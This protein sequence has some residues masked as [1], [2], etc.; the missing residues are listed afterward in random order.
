MTEEKPS[1]NLIFS[2][3]I[4]GDPAPQGSLKVERG[5]IRQS[6]RVKAWRRTCGI[7]AMRQ[8]LQMAHEG[9]IGIELR[10]YLP[11][12]KK[13]RKPD[14]DKLV[15]AVLD[16]FTGILYK[17]D[18]QVCDLRAQKMFG[19]GGPSPAGVKVECWRI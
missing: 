3:F 15:R 1:P 6:E 11:A 10:F 9:S 2:G 13:G 14:L 7:V 8:R 18:G 16:A 17:D 5:R 19:F 4:E 12:G